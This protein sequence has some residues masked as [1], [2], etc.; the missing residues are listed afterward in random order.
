M[1]LDR[2]TTVFLR[3]A[4]LRIVLASMMIVLLGPSNASVAQSRSEVEELRSL[5]EQTQESMRRMME[6]HQRQIDMLQSRIEGLERRTK[7]T[8]Q[9]QKDIGDE[10]IEQGIALGEIRSSPRDRLIIHGYYDVQYLNAED[11]NVGSFVQNELSI[12]LQHTTEDERWTFFSEIEFEVLEGDE[13]FFSD[14]ERT[15]E[16]EIETAWVEYLVSDELQVRAGKLLLPQYWQTYHYPNITLSTR[17]PSMVGRIFPKD[18]IGLEVRGDWWWN[19]QRGL[20]YV[21]YIGNGGDS[22]FSEVD[23]NDN[24]AIGGHLTI[25]LAGDGIFDTLDIGV[26]AYSGRDHSD[27]NETIFGFDTQIR[28][29]NFELLSEF[30]WGDQPGDVLMRTR[31]RSRASSDNFGFYVQLAYGFASK[32]HGFYRFDEL[33]LLDSGSSALDA[34]QHTLGVNFRPLSNISLK[35]EGFR[36]YPDGDLDAFN[37]IATS[38]VYNF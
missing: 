38:V 22:E 29:K 15:S 25:R 14:E 8:E 26:S 7:S 36:A 17:Q 28:V 12:F 16:I 10:L 34:H 4:L 37:G 2:S 20:S 13:F 32:W 27:E 30:A 18:I 11:S 33:D 31:A 24:T 21:I 23:R 35:L 6:E 9:S 19:D 5:L 1:P 3:M